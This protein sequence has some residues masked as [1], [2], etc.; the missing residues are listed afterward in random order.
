MLRAYLERTDSSGCQFVDYD[1]LYRR[2]RAQKPREVLEC[3]TGCSTL[4]IAHALKEN[5]LRDGVA[6]R[7]TS[8]EDVD[9]WYEMARK[10]LPDELR[11]WVDLRLSPKIEDA[12]TIF[13]GVRYAE[14]PERPYDF[15]FTD[16]PGTTAPSDGARS[17]DFDYLHVVR[18]SDSPVS[19]IVDGRLTTCYVLQKVFGPERFRFDVY[20]NLGFVGPCTKYDLGALTRSSSE[21]LS[22]SLRALRRTRFHLEMERRPPASGAGPLR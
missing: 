10:L 11:D 2:I 9:H 16:G 1:A 20:R 18:R 21:A 12:Y 8:M 6:G 14:L 22:H 17:F 19:G 5:Q 15:V 13:R 7:L 4:V 3:G